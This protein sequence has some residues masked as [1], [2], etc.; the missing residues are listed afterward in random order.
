MIKNDWNDADN[1][2]DNDDKKKPITATNSAWDT[3]LLHNNNDNLDERTSLRGFNPLNYDA[4]KSKSAAASPHRV[5]GKS[6]RISLRATQMEELNR[7]LLD[8]G[9]FSGDRRDE[10]MRAVLQQYR[11]FLLEPLEDPDAVLEENSIYSS[12][13]SRAERY[14]AFRRSLSERIESSKNLKVTTAL[15]AMKNF[16]LEFE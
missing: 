7:L 6:N 8:A 5:A 16:V 13:M 14:Q 2:S 4:S 10:E 12:Q 15:Q 9:G 11:D 3:T 1:G